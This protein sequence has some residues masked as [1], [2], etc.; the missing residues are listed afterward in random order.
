[1]PNSPRHLAF[2]QQQIA[3][4]PLSLYIHL[5]WCIQ[6][7]PYCD[8]NSHAINT[9]S[10]DEMAYI[11]SLLMDLDHELVFVQN[12]PIHSIFIGGGTPSIFS[13][14][15]IATLL[16]GIQN[17]VPLKENA[18]ITLEANPGTFEQSKFAGFKQAGINR[19]SIGIQSFHNHHLNTLGRIHNS[20]EALHAVEMALPLFEVVN[21]DLMYALPSQT[22]EEARTDI[23]TAIDLGVNHISAYHLT[24]ENN[25]AF[26]YRPPN[27][28]PDTDQAQDIEDAVH[29]SL[30]NAGF[31]HY[32]ISAFAKNGQFCQHNLNYW[33]FGDYLGIGAGAHGKVTCHN[34]IERTAKTKH[35]QAYICNIGDEQ[36][37]LMRHI[38]DTKDLP[39]EFMMNAMRLTEGVA[40][41]TFQERCALPLTQIKPMIL[42]A[43]KLNLIDFTEEYIRPTEQGQR[44]L[45]E[46]LLLFLSE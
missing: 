14:N 46:L 41:S 33:Q 32:E 20:Q 9:A 11:Q 1:M 15:A 2:D 10:I 42:Q 4:I 26:G 25:T 3:N 8:F 12:R 38:I 27:N 28:L 7:C 31:T 34:K 5:P 29:N 30:I 6:K 44:F 36:K 17:K 24:I 13:E 39:F 16:E 21:V 45:N 18:E 37:H 22:I 43:Q 19:L 35:P 40:T 23:Q